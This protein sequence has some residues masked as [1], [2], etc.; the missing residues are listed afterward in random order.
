VWFPIRVLTPAGEQRYKIRQRQ[1]LVSKRRLWG[2]DTVNNR[3]L[4]FPLQGA[5]TRPPCASP[6]ATIAQMPSTIPK[7]H[8]P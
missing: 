3:A 2:A 7:G 5:A 6:A 4:D 8:A 1:Q